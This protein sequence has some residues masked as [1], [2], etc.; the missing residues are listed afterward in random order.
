ML[1]L[2]AC[3]QLERLRTPSPFAGDARFDIVLA[4]DTPVAEAD[5]AVIQSRLQAFGL[6]GTVT[7]SGPSRLALHLEGVR[8]ADV[9][10]HLLVPGELGFYEVLDWPADT[11]VPG[12]TLEGAT[13]RAPNAETVALVAPLPDTRVL[14]Q[15]EEERGCE[16]L[17]LRTP[18]GLTGR[19][20]ANA[21]F[22]VADWG[23]Q[24]AV[25]FTRSG[26]ERFGALSAALVNHR[27]AI[28]VDDEVLSTPLIREPIT[29][30][31]A[32]ISMGQPGTAGLEDAVALAGALQ[33]GA[34][35]GRWVIERM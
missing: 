11:S 12:A 18:P 17:L 4:A 29:G 15:C 16:A 26:G 8:D 34:L 33:G 5:A 10:R 22:E 14:P 23:P 24:V 28:V 27:L 21:S 3:A 1:L 31:N 32:V 30:G 7:P 19:D 6:D 20:L 13:L 9:V 2:L 35:T 25:T